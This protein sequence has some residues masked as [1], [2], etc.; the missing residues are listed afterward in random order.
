[1]TVHRCLWCTADVGREG[2]TCS[3]ECYLKWYAFA[4]NRARDGYLLRLEDDEPRPLPL[5]EQPW[6]SRE[7]E[8][9]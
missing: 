6:Y 5:E 4:A 9:E 3:R 7:I 2:Y 8:G 1:M